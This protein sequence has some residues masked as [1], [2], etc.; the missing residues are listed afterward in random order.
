[1][2]KRHSKE[3]QA[4]R[5]KKRHKGILLV[6]FPCLVV[7]LLCGMGVS[8][9]I[10]FQKARKKRAQAIEKAQSE[11]VCSIWGH[12]GKIMF[13]NIIEATNNFNDKYLIGVR[14]QGSISM[15]EL[16][17]GQVFA[18]KKFH[19]ETDGEISMTSNS[20]EL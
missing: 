1:M 3:A 17:S 18:V 8:M 6:L 9:Y 14:G 7:L 15:V 5:I 20:F 10:L 12:D 16:P 2:W 13:E 11:E 19:L 4:N